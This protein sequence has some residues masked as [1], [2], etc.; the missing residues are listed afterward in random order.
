MWSFSEN[1][2]PVM[3]AYTLKAFSAHSNTISKDKSY[4]SSV[5]LAYS[6]VITE[7]ERKKATE[8]PVL[9]PFPSLPFPS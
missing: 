1:V 7:K 6:V 3:P 2:F 4:L 5:K 9:L 8:A